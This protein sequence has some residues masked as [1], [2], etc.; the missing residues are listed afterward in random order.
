MTTPFFSISKQQASDRIN[1]DS[2]LEC[3]IC[4][5]E[6]NPVNGDPEREIPAGTP[7]STLP[8][9]WRCPVCDSDKQGFL[10]VGA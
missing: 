9:Q 1:L 3:K 10:V 8:D 7:F 5:Y 2:H 4:W 6:Y